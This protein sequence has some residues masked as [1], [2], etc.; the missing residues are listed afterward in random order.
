MKMIPFYPSESSRQEFSVNL[1]N[2]VG[3]FNVFWNERAKSWFFDLSTS[4]GAIYGVRIVESTPIL[5]ETNSLGL[6]GNI[7]VLKTNKLCKESITYDNFGSDWTLV[8]GYTDE[9][10]EFDSIMGSLD[11]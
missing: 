4:S 6:E 1:G 8:F 7:R 5:P 11:G 3:F 9:W 10:T 2:M